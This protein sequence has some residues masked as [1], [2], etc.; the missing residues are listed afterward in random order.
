MRIAI[1]TDEII[2]DYMGAGGIRMLH[3]A[4]YL[5]STGHKVVI[6]CNSRVGNSEHNNIE[7]KAAELFNGEFR[8]FDIAVASTLTRRSLKGLLKFEKPIIHDLICPFMLENIHIFSNMSY[9]KRK[10]W[11]RE[12]ER[13]FLALASRSSAWLVASQRQRIFWLGYFEKASLLKSEHHESPPFIE[14]PNGVDNSVYLLSDELS[15]EA[16]SLIKLMDSDEDTV[17]IITNGGMYGWFLYEPLLAAFAQLRSAGYPARLILLGANHPNNSQQSGLTSERILKHAND[18]GITEN[19]FIAKWLPY[20][21]RFEV[22]KR[23]TLGVNIHP[24]GIETELAYRNRLLDFA[25]C[26]VPLVTSIGD[27]V[28]ERMIDAGIAIPLIGYDTT[29]IFRVLQRALD[30]KWGNSYHIACAGFRSEWDWKKFVVGIDRA[31]E[32]AHR[33]ESPYSLSKGQPPGM[34]LSIYCF[35]RTIFKRLSGR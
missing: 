14:L 19:I 29:N 13:D 15:S 6:F 4:E 17:N 11:E 9:L 18:L 25:A 26:E 20:K 10:S 23:A 16:E 5:S 22:L 32:A 24:Q 7:L 31:I 30:A 28:S 3:I 8:D 21:E 27:V 33:L 34:Y 1:V 2:G 35:L 12:F